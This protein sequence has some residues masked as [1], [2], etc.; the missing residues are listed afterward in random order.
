[1]NWYLKFKVLLTSFLAVNVTYRA[2]NDNRRLRGENMR[3]L[4]NEMHGI[5]Y[6]LKRNAEKKDIHK[7]S[8][9]IRQQQRNQNPDKSIAD[10]LRPGD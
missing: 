5:S 2:S 8:D 3:R 10:Q 9:K 6:L 4:K 7:L 1:M